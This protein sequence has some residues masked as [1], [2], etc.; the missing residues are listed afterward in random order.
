MNQ[1]QIPTEY[2]NKVAA[3]IAMQKLAE[4]CRQLTEQMEGKGQAIAAQQETIERMASEKAHWKPMAELGER[5]LQQKKADTLN[6]LRAIVHYTGETNRIA[7]LNQTFEQ[8][9]LTC[10]EVERL[11]QTINRE[12]QTLY[13][14]QPHSH[15]N[16]EHEL[17]T[18][19]QA[20]W[21]AYRLS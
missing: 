21:S 13:P 2:Q 3:V 19:K 14:T 1:N 9:G 20:D 12:F 15:P 17:Q 16:C 4:R 11:Y 7:D 10:E 5:T 8:T 6:R 18:M